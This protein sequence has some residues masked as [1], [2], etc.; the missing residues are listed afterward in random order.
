[1]SFVRPDDPTYLHSLAQRIRELEA[2]KQSLVEKI[3][4]IEK[5]S[6]V[7]PLDGGVSNE[8]LREL[9]SR[10]EEVMG[11]G[12]IHDRR[13]L[14]SHVVNRIELGERHGRSRARSLVVQAALTTD[15]GGV[16]SGI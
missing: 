3:Q 16:P 8:F 1:M 10:F 14:L 15:K 13:A 7:I 12:D 11:I 5:A 6:R 4:E 2:E 9:L